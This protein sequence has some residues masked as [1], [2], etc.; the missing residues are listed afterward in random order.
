MKMADRA[1]VMMRSEQ[2]AAFRVDD[3][4]AATL[5]AYGDT[6]FGRACLA[7]RRLVEVGVPAVEVTLDGWDTHV[8]N[9]DLHAGL[10]GTLDQAFAALLADLA[11]RDLLRRT[12]VACGGE[13]GRTPRINAV[14]GRD[15][16]TRGFTWLLGG[17]GLRGGQVIG[18]TDPAGE[19]DPTDP[20]APADML[21]TIYQ[22]L[23]VEQDQEFYTDAGRPVKLGEGAPLAKLLA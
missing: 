16:W 17:R 13:F 19:A 22:A 23:D 12:V 21:A 15:H 4:P 9:F 14:E 6:P 3:E 18:E 2:M 20:V 10:A 8:N 11:E 7:A 5:A 1:H